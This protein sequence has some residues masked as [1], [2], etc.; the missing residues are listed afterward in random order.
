MMIINVKI[1]KPDGTL[2]KHDFSYRWM[3][4]NDIKIGEIV[5]VP[6]QNFDHIGIEKAQVTGV[7][8]QSNPNIRYKIVMRKDKIK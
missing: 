2:S 7:N 4:D 5:I 3:F 8:I 6:V 1:I